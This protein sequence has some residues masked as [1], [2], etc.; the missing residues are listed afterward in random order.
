MKEPAH[1]GES[2]ATA[3]NIL[4]SWGP[5]MEILLNATESK[6]YLWL[7]TAVTIMRVSSHCVHRL[8]KT[9]GRIASSFRAHTGVRL[10]AF[11]SLPRLCDV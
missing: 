10:V 6:I 7:K 9:E 5:G 3:D 11:T 8:N 4:E 1:Q 2:W